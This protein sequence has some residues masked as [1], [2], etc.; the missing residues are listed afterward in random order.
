MSKDIKD[1][2]ILDAWAEVMCRWHASLDSRPRQVTELV[3]KGIPEALRGE[4][5]LL[6][7]GTRDNQ[8]LLESYRIL[9]TKVNSLDIFYS[10][11]A[12]VLER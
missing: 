10:F 12:F 5:W 9:L 4:V 11:A 8:Q 2:N 3:R 1:G 6:L 7:S